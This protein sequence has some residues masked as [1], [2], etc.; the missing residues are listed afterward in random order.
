MVL[1]NFQSAQLDVQCTG[2]TV[3]TSCVQWLFSVLLLWTTLYCSDLACLSLPNKARLNISTAVKISQ[4]SVKVSRVMHVNYSFCEHCFRLRLEMV[5]IKRDLRDFKT[6]HVQ[7]RPWWSNRTDIP[8]WV[9][10]YKSLGFSHCFRGFQGRCQSNFFFKPGKAVR[11]EGPQ[12]V[13]VAES[14]IPPI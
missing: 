9:Q 10:M 1:V 3:M 4:W 6:S 12:D 5:Q 7:W 14:R 2:T 11:V 13:V 8:W